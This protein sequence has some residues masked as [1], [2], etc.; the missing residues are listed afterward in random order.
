M[1]GKTQKKKLQKS[2]SK[3]DQRWLTMQVLALWSV[4]LRCEGV[5]L[6]TADAWTILDGNFNITLITPS[7][8]PRVLNQP[9][10]EARGGVVTHTDDE[11][12][13]IKA[14]ATQGRVQDAG[15]V[16]PENLLV[17]LDRDSE[18]LSHEGTLHL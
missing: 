5:H 2:I 18:G 1:K 12:G 8:V 9:I 10:V 7:G 6:D 4:S 15:S 17:S 13:V 11:D 3:E 16:C 14:G